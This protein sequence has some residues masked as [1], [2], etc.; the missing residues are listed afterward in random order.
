MLRIDDFGG[1]DG[2]MISAMTFL[3]CDKDKKVSSS[4][5]CQMLEELEE[6]AA[7]GQLEKSFVKGVGLMRE[8]LIAVVR[9]PR[10]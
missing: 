8:R 4:P 6:L 10:R 2:Y 3:H 5:W 1:V 9:D 7:S